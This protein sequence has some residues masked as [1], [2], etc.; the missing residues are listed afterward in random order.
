MTPSQLHAKGWNGDEGAQI[1]LAIPCL[2]EMLTAHSNKRA[3]LKGRLA[4]T[5]TASVLREAGL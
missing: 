3:T 5:G 2:H 1:L 4:D